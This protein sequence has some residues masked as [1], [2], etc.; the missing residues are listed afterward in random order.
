M[1][2]IVWLEG[3]FNLLFTL[4]SKGHVYCYNLLQDFSSFAITHSDEHAYKCLLIE[5]YLIL[6]LKKYAENDIFFYKISLTDIQDGKFEKIQILSQVKAKLDD[7]KDIDIQ[8][9]TMTIQTQTSIQIWNILD[10]TLY[11]QFPTNPNLTFQFS[12][13]RLLFWQATSSVT[14]IGIFSIVNQR[15]NTVIVNSIVKSLP[16]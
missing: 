8:S 11:Y 3:R 5:D 6:I 13:K 4:D 1:S 2:S 9:K 10:N 12:S 14:S 16:E 15:L 7:I